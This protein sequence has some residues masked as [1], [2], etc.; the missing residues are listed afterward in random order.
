MKTL[1]VAYRVTDLNRSLAFYSALGYIEVGQVAV[2]DG[3]RLIFLKFPDEPVITLELV[4]RPGDGR[5][6]VGNGFDHLVIQADALADTRGILTEAGLEPAP[7]Q[8]PAG[9]DGPLTSWLTDPDGYPIELVEW[10]PGHAD[11]ITAADFT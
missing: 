11:G 5:V 7:L 4:H 9:I 6:D 2:G 10:P 3:T 8:Y 1:H